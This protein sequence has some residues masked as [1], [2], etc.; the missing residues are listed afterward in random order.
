MAKNFQLWESIKAF[1][2]CMDNNI[3]ALTSKR[4]SHHQILIN[5][6][7]KVTHNLINPHNLNKSVP[8]KRSIHT[9]TSFPVQLHTYNQF[10]YF[11]H[12]LREISLVH[13][14]YDAT[15]C[16]VKNQFSFFASFIMR[17]VINS[18]E[19]L[20][21]SVSIYY[22]CHPLQKSNNKLIIIMNIQN[23][24]HNVKIKLEMETP[25]TMMQ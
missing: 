14:I 15:V 25:K 12:I 13:L 1:L 23:S 7:N 18:I 24:E 6:S 9:P 17:L 22:D 8:R 4:N 21:I 20:S 3:K 2:N 16:I 19:A 10:T 11:L 5:L